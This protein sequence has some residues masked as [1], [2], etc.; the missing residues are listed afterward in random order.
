[1]RAHFAANIRNRSIVVPGPAQLGHLALPRQLA[2]QKYVP[3]RFVLVRAAGRNVTPIL[4]VKL[5]MVEHGL[6]VSKDEV[7]A[8]FDIAM[9]VILPPPVGVERVLPAE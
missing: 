1:M 5:A 3:P 4:A 9:I 2:I 6:R 8:A 7:G